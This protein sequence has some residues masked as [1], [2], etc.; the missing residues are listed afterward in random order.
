MT[1]IFIIVAIIVLIWYRNAKTKQ[2][3]L[4]PPSEPIEVASHS[5]PDKTYKVCPKDVWCSC[6][7]WQKRRYD[8]E[9]NDPRRVCKHLASIYNSDPDSIPDQLKEYLPLFSLCADEGKYIQCKSG[10]SVIVIDSQPYIIGPSDEKGWVNISTTGRKQYGLNIKEHRF[11][12]GVWP[13][14]W[15]DVIKEAYRINGKKMNP[16]FFIQANTR[17]SKKRGYTQKYQI[18]K[19]NFKKVWMDNIEQAIEYKLPYWFEPYPTSHGYKLEN[20]IDII[21]EKNTPKQII[22]KDKTFINIDNSF[23]FSDDNKEIIKKYWNDYLNSSC[24]LHIDVN[25]IENTSKNEKVVTTQEEIDSFCIIRRILFDTVQPYRINFYDMVTY[26]AVT[27]DHGKKNYI[28]K[29]YFNGK[30]KKIGVFN[31][32]AEEKININSIE[33]IYNYSTIFINTT[34]QML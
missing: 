20:F 24:P 11:S 25:T 27:L 7:D 30:Q 16:E 28:C 19:I 33:D 1:F 6:P 10:T 26:F 31:N 5:E 22:F 9:L 13:A 15:E 34:E 12:Y 29:L 32:N 3:R 8:M 21:L 2:E 17:T 18:D 23:N 14:H 4:I